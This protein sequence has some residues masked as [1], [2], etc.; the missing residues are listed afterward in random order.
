LTYHNVV[1]RFIFILMIALL[2]LRGWMGEAMATEMAAINIIANQAANTLASVDLT[3]AKSMS[4]CDMHKSKTSDSTVK[5]TA[6]PSCTHC[7]ACHAAGMVGTVQITSF[8]TIR[9]APPLAQASQFASASI[10]HS[11]KPPIL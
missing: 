9:Y 10:A 5:T 1:R 6:K 4:D 2:P 7:Q 11:Q 8:D 3:S